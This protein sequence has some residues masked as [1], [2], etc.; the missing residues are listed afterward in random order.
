MT[1][2]K[3]SELRYEIGA[4]EMRNGGEWIKTIPGDKWDRGKREGNKG[5]GEKEIK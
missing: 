3:V 5:K 4:E 1:Y 2:K